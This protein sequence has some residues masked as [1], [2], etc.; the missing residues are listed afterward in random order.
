METDFSFVELATQWS[1]IFS[2][3]FIRYF[4]VSGVVYLILWKWL[5]P[6]LT[7]RMLSPDRLRKNQI[8]DEII[9][10]LKVGVVFTIGGTSMG[11]LQKNG[12]GMW[13][14]DIA[15]FGWGYFVAQ[16]FIMVAIGDLYFYW[17][18]RLMHIPRLFK[19]I[20]SVHHKS[21]NPTPFTSMSVDFAEGVLNICV[22]FIFPFVMPVHF[23]AFL[24][25]TLV[26]FFYNV[27]AHCG[28]DILPKGSSQHFL[29]KYFNSSPD[30]NLHHATSRGNYGFYT[31]VWDRVF[32]TYV[33]PDAVKLR[34]A[35]S[36]QWRPRT[37]S[38][39]AEV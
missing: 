1:K 31:T 12:I 2:Y 18:H 25:Y 6:K 35:K 7:A 19:W 33:S 36:D 9:Q 20:H 37:L 15:Q 21:A 24:L 23:S 30:H 11:L 26:A 16:V 5:A 29:L 27:Y 32:G 14:T 10:S 28:Y 4:V 3:V 8:R 38:S 17:T 22:V 39:T 34:P 13:Y